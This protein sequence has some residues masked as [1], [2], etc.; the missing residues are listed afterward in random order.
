MTPAH[1]GPRLGPEQARKRYGL[2]GQPEVRET[3]RLPKG[4]PV[5]R[6]KALGGG[7][8]QEEWTSPRRVPPEAIRKVVPIRWH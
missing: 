8:G 7:P 1:P 6:N 3:I 2:P 4:H 5:R